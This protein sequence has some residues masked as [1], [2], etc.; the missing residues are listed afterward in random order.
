MI[1]TILWSKKPTGAGEIL[2]FRHSV[3]RWSKTALRD[4]GDEVTYD[5]GME[6]F[7]QL[8]RK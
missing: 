3:G 7:S 6:C 4:C 1:S 8:A 2:V 5:L